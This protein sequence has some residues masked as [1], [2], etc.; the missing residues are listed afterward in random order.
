MAQATVLQEIKRRSVFS[1][2]QGSVAM[3]ALSVECIR[4]QLFVGRCLSYSSLS[5]QMPCFLTEQSGY[6]LF[7]FHKEDEQDHAT[8]KQ[9]LNCLVDILCCQ[10]LPSYYS[11]LVYFPSPLNSKWDFQLLLCVFK[12]KSYEYLFFSFFFVHYVKT[13]NYIKQ[14]LISE[15]STYKIYLS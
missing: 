8:S 3:A 11:F 10:L 7:F 6:L 14:V 15:I 12:N 4:Q 2:S 1:L 9:L 5:V 13:Y